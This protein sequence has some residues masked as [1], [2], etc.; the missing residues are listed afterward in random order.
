MTTFVCL[1]TNIYVRFISQGMPGCEQ[2]H[3]TA[4]I[5]RVRDG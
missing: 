1:D 4:L 2:E 3:W 5:S